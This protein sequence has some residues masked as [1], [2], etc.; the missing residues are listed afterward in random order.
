MGDNYT[1]QMIKELIFYFNRLP[2]AKQRNKETDRQYLAGF[3]LFATYQYH[4]LWNARR[5]LKT[6]K[7]ENWF[8]F[9]GNCNGTIKA[10][11]CDQGLTRTLFFFKYEK[12]N[13]N[14]SKNNSNQHK[15]ESLS[16]WE[17]NC[18]GIV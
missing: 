2:N 3:M 8:K 16:H 11:K 17:E 1:I 13:N 14:Q 9:Y 15:L 18:P 6:Y 4:N 5:A 12:N 10:Y 7:L